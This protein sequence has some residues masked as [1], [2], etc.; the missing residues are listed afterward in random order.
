MLKVMKLRTN[1]KYALVVPTSIGVRLLPP[2]RQ[3]VSSSEL[4][5]MQATSA[6]TNTAS[7]CSYLGLPVKVL[8]TFV[9][10]SPIAQF[11]KAN[12]R[13]RNMEVEG[14]ELEQGGPWGYRHQ[15]NIADSGFG[16]RGPRVHNDRAGEVGKT[17]NAK[18]FDFEKL[19]GEDGVA[20][21]H[22][23]GLICALSK[24]TGE[25]CL[26]LAKTAKKYGTIISFDFNYRASFWENRETELR[27]IFKE[28]SKQADIIISNKWD[29]EKCLGISFKAELDEK[30]L[31]PAELFK[32]TVKQIK[33]E[34]PDTSV[35]ATTLRD[36]K[37]ANRHFWGAVMQSGD[38]FQYI[39][40]R[41][42]AVLDRIGG[43]D[44]FVGGMLYGILNK[45]EPA[46][47]LQF[48]WA[49]GALATTFLT[50][51]IQPDSEEQIW[52]IWNGNIRIER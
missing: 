25:F 48:G 29:Y 47:Q 31:S 38:D 10:G 5:Y 26:E 40:Q 8:T 39:E 51:Y 33:K 45:W 37:H 22:L 2:D 18:D 43:G 19:F 14:K 41:E 17:L 7:V 44:A 35:F 21:L 6:E 28:I 32:E 34:F 24:E 15:F 13:S 9:K 50:D 27:Q 30:L 23:T 1:Y 36:V 4:F 12:L 46:K 52:K 20:I 3:T 49:C 11:I 42:I 16:L